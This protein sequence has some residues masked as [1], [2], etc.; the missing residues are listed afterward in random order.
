MPDTCLDIKNDGSEENLGHNACNRLRFEQTT[1]SFDFIN[2]V[3]KFLLIFFQNNRSTA[4]CR[5][6][7]IPNRLLLKLIYYG[8]IRRGQDSIIVLQIISL[9]IKT[10]PGGQN[11]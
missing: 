11:I 5:E 3:I 4:K 9:K 2:F 6:K 7:D 8:P 1:W 10:V